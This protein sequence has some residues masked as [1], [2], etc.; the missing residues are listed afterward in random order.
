[1]NAEQYIGKLD[2]PLKEIVK[3]LRKIVT[4][5]S[6]DI[7]EEMK[8]NVPTYSINKNICS[9]MA[10]KKHVNFQIFRGAHIKD[11]EELE[12]TGKDMRHLKFSTLG[13]VEEAKME[14]YLKQAIGNRSDP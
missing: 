1:M 6:S 2:S 9:I 11:A 14:K 4:N 7:K 8:W 13:E 3:E 10:H 12:G 5:H